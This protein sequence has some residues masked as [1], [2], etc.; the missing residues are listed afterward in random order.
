MNR[1]AFYAVVSTVVL[2]LVFAEI[3]LIIKNCIKANKC[4]KHIKIKNVNRGYSWLI[5]SVVIF[6]FYGGNRHFLVF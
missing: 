6:F 3:F 1:V 5:L 4:Q 2:G